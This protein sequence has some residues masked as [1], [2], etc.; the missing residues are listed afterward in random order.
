MS[1]QRIKI[2][3]PKDRYD[4]DRSVG[5]SQFHKHFGKLQHPNCYLCSAERGDRFIKV[6][7]FGVDYN[8]ESNRVSLTCKCH[9]DIF[10][11]QQDLGDLL[12]QK[13]IDTRMVFKPRQG[14]RINGRILC[15]IP[16]RHSQDETYAY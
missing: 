1:F 16:R 5:L 6:D 3:D 15:I 8:P 10:E 9:K 4:T 14:T 12:F 13:K 7:V 11:M 2:S